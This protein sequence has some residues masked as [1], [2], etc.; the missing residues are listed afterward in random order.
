MSNMLKVTILEPNGRGW[1]E[2]GS[3]LLPPDSSFALPLGRRELLV[4]P[5]EDDDMRD[6]PAK[7]EMQ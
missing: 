5:V 1:V 3:E 4:E 2:V 6:E 7:E